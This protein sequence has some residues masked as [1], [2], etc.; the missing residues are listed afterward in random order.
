VA[1]P[2]AAADAWGAAH[3]RGTHAGEAFKEESP[4]YDDLANLHYTQAVLREALRLYSVVPVVTRQA[5][6]DDVICGHPIPANSHM[7]VHIK[8][9]HYRPDLWPEP[10]AFRPERFEGKPQYH[11]FSFLPFINGPR[12][13]IG[14]HFAQLEAKIVLALLVNR[15]EV[16]PAPGELGQRHPHNI[17]IAP[18]D[19]MRVTV[20]RRA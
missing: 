16:T 5:V 8:A 20:K 17:P 1:A 2:F 3:A 13:C 18:R 12:N 7:V 14:Q 6:E 11:P 19:W 9:I 4:A 10:D 15:F